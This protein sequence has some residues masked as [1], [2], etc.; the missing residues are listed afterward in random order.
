MDICQGNLESL[1]KKQIAI[2][3][4]QPIKASPITKVKAK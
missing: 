2:N 3:T 1:L 4:F